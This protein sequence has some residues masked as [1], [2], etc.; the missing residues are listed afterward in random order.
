[1]KAG[2]CQA[3]DTNHDR[4]RLRFVGRILLW[5]LPL[6]GNERIIQLT[7]YSSSSIAGTSS[8]KRALQHDSSD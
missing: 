8:D 1:M 7:T 4:P 5:Y 2:D 3:K 6:E